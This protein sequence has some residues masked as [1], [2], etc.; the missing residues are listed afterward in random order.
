MVSLFLFPCST[1]CQSYP[2]R[3]ITH[4][5]ELLNYDVYSLA[6]LAVYPD[7][8][9]IGSDMCNLM[10]EPASVLDLAVEQVGALHVY[11]EGK[12]SVNMV[13]MLVFEVLKCVGFWT[14]LRV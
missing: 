7:G 1:L 8:T 6:R 12:S 3:Q 10:Q 9:H 4:P 11:D 5:C 14:D 2:A 13:T